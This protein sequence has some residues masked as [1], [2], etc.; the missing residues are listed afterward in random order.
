M[1]RRTKR[2][3]TPV[4]ALFLILAFCVGAAA[5]VYYRYTL[6][7]PTDSDPFVTGDLTVHFLEL[8]NDRAGDCV[9]IQIGSVDVLVDAGSNKDS[10]PTIDAY[11]QKQMQDD[12]LDYVI[13]THAHEDHYAGFATDKKTDSLFDL[14]KVGTII[15]FAKTNQKEQGL[16]ANYLRE[17]ADEIADGAAHYTALDCVTQNK[18]FTLATGVT[19]EI[20]DNYYYTHEAESENDYS[21][22]FLLR[23]D[24]RTFLFTGDLESGAEKKLIELNPD[25]KDVTLYKAGHHGSNTSSCE[26]FMARIRPEI[27]CICACAGSPEYT[28]DPAGQFPTQKVINRIAPYTDKVYVTS[29]Y[30]ASV[31]GGR[32]SLN[33]DI[34][35][36]SGKTLTVRGSASS[37]PLKDS[38]WFQQNRTLPTEWQNA[39]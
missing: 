26:A 12:V 14:Y 9:F 11:L 7:L 17:R 13:V 4:V 27:V 24:T 29:R 5:G 3:S 35:V 21:V 23:Q 19:L 15:D 1:A 25:L 32:A 22:C 31:T 20:L 38:A 34:V 6:D 36:T 39:A 8:G 28:S 10:I 16:Y 30:D 2:F 18:D 37:L 33:G